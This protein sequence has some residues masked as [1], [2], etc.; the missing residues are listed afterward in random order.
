M[1]FAAPIVGK[2]LASCAAS[3]AAAAVLP[4]DSATSATPAVDGRGGVNA[5]AFAQT[6]DNVAQAPAPKPPHT[7]IVTL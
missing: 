3:Q 1:I 4:G 6:L 5:A 2:I 7:D